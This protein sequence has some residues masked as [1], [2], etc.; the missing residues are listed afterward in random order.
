VTPSFAEVL[1]GFKPAS[2]YFTDD[3]AV[4]ITAKIPESEAIDGISFKV[5]FSE[6]LNVED[7]IAT[8]DLCDLDGVVNEGEIEILCLSKPGEKIFGSFGVVELHLTSEIKAEYDLVIEEIDL[9]S[10]TNA[11][12]ESGNYLLEIDELDSTS[13][14]GTLVNETSDSLITPQRLYALVLVLVAIATVVTAVLVYRNRRRNVVQYRMFSLL[15]LGLGVIGL[16]SGSYLIREDNLD[17]RSDASYEVENE[18][19]YFDNPTN[20]ADLNHDDIIDEI[21]YEIFYS[22]ML[23]WKEIGEL[24]SRSDLNDDLKIDISDYSIFVEKAGE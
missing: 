10:D 5:K 18:T 21:D 23:L 19:F 12:G 2:G 16:I 17:S 14:A 13:L 7:Y 22:D 15:L 20:S 9:G 11:V 24:N 1:M 3:L 4:E 8:T 6:D